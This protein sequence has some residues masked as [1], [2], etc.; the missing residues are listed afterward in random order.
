MKERN[1]D[2]ILWLDYC[3]TISKM[4]KPGEMKKLS[5]LLVVMA[6][7][8]ACNSHESPKSG[9]PGPSTTNVQ[10]VNG[11]Q[12]DTS[13]GITLDNRQAGDST[14]KDSLKR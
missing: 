14:N 10:N 6:V 4:N 1:S 5:C 9:S 8:A 3:M 7:L 13:T 2:C 12:P 11:N